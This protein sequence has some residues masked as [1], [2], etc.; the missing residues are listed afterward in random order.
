[1]VTKTKKVV[2]PKKSEIVRGY[3]IK[4]HFNGKT[5]WSKRKMKDGKPN[6]YW[7]WHRSDG[8]LKRSGNFKEGNIVGEWATYDTVGKVYKVTQKK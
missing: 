4:Y 2:R 1:M 5:V 6:G 8:T 3:T 7:E